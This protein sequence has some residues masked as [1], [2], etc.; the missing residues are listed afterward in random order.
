MF[1][2]WFDKWNSDNPTNIFGPAIA[3]GV[4]G[5]GVRGAA[6]IVAWGQP[7]A[8]TSQQTGPRGTGGD[9]VLDRDSR[10]AGARNDSY[11]TQVAYSMIEMTQNIN[12]NW[13][14]H[15]QANAEVGSPVTPATADSRAEQ[16]LVP[17]R[18]R[19]LERRPGGPPSRTG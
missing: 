13:A 12:E 14:A 4:A 11:Q 2:K 8:T 10:S 1:P 5:G 18:S 7:F 17:G 9:A 3:V 16:R 19:Q 6:M 15:V